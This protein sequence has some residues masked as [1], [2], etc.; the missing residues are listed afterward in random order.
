MSANSLCVKKKNANQA[1]ARIPVSIFGLHTVGLFDMGA[2]LSFCNVKMLEWI[3]KNL[4]AKKKLKL[5]AHT[6]PIPQSATSQSINIIGNVEFELCIGNTM[7]KCEFLV[8]TNLE[9]KLI[10]GK[11]IIDAFGDCNISLNHYARS[12]LD[13]GCF[14]SQTD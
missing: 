5:N 1:E 10:L 8:A 13:S 14:E 11:D 6:G 2:V 4:C 7:R 3:S 9:E 12:V